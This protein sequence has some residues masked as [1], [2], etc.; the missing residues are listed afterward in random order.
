MQFLTAKRDGRE[1]DRGV[2][3]VILVKGMKLDED[4]LERFRKR[5]SA[6]IGNELSTSTSAYMI[7]PYTV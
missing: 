2:G 7:V 3:T 5:N 4:R 6:K 1:R